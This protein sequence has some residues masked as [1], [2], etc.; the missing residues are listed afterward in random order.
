MSLIGVLPPDEMIGSLR[1]FFVV[2]VPDLILVHGGGV[3]IIVFPGKVGVDIDLQVRGV[4]HLVFEGGGIQADLF[5][6]DL[7]CPS[8][9][10]FDELRVI[11]HG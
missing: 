2:R 6:G 1:E 7:I 4:L 10:V 5:P 8:P 3:K 11:H 9:V